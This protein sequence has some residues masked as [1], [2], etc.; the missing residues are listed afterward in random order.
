MRLIRRI[1]YTL[2]S[3]WTAMIDRLWWW[4]MEDENC[5]D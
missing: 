5:G 1:Y 4:L 2:Y 3:L